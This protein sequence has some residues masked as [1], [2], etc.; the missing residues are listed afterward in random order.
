MQN[1]RQIKLRYEGNNPTRAAVLLAHALSENGI[2]HQNFHIPR[3][4]RSIVIFNFVSVQHKE[5][6]LQLPNLDAEL[7]KHQFAPMATSQFRN[8]EHRTVFINQLYPDFFY[9]FQRADGWETDKTLDKKNPLTPVIVF[10][11]SQIVSQIYK[12]F[13]Q[14]FINRN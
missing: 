10:Q 14:V 8:C 5:R 4:H 1:P 12:H 9:A 3:D 11:I 7:R 13:Y 6:A 2:S